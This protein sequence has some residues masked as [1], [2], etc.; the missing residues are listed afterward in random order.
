MLDALQ[1]ESIG[2]RAVTA[3]LDT[4]TPFG[5]ELV[6]KP[7]FFTRAE[8]R[9]LKNEQKNIQT[10]MRLCAESPDGVSAVERV[11]MPIKDVRRTI[12]RCGG[13]TALTEVELFEL[14]RFLLS[15]ELLCEKIEPLL[16]TYPLYDTIL[17]PTGGALSL[18]DP[19][20]TRTP[21]FYIS[22]SFSKRLAAIRAERKRIDVLLRAGADENLLLERTRLAAEEENETARIRY[23]MTVSLGVFRD[24]MLCNA[25]AIGK[26][27]F[28]LAK[29]KL[30]LAYGAVMPS[31]ND[32]ADFEMRG[33]TNPQLAERLAKQ[34]KRF[35]PISISL[36]SGSTVITGANMGGKS[37]AIRTLALNVQLAMCGYAVFAESASMPWIGG[38]FLLSEDKEDSSSGLSSFGG[39][40]KAFDAI[41]TDT[42]K[43]QNALVLLDEFAR[44]TNPHEG[45]ALVRAAVRCFNERDVRTFAVIATHFD[46]VAIIA[47]A[48]YQVAGLRGADRQKLSQEMAAG[49]SADVLSRHMDYGLYPVPPDA[50]PPRD[51]ITIC[52]ALGVSPKF[53]QLIEK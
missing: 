4:L 34:G 5:A 33:M 26:L 52:T 6:R 46:G 29:A 22:D 47:R 15:L 20:R 53:M 36:T 13:D 1:L 12:S 48:H 50:E 30:A 35:T 43:M 41:L 28:A 2:F 17:T 14:K 18:I 31:I 39:E 40:M 45:T 49:D 42:E 7:R 24:E 11:L 44:G 23:D 19:D 32:Q 27:D 9:Q 37:V 10:L 25:N 8:E 16:E 51:A 3:R 38:V 21:S